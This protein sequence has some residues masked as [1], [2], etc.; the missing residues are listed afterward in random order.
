MRTHDT[1]GRALNAFDSQRK[2]Y[3]SL[4]HAHQPLVAVKETGLHESSV[5]TEDEGA[6]DKPGSWRQSLQVVADA[7][8]RMVSHYPQGA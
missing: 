3:I 2:L 1:T 7:L 5:S 8:L 6:S 4:E